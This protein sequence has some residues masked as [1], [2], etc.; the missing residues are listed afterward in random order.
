[1]RILEELW[2]GNITPNAREFVRGTVFD[3]ACQMLCKNEEKLNALLAEKEQEIFRNYQAC[4]SEITQISECET[5]ISGFRL[6]ARIILE[7]LSENEST[8]KSIV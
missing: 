1:M 7:V 2:Y 5:F 3:E 4:Q 8:F 6:G